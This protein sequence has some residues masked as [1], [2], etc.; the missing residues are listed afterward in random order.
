MRWPGYG[1]SDVTLTPRPWIRHLLEFHD[2]REI[3][4]ING[5][6][7][8]I[9]NHKTLRIP[10]LHLRLTLCGVG[11]HY[12]NPWIS[13]MTK[14]SSKFKYSFT[15]FATSLTLQCPGFSLKWA[16]WVLTISWSSKW[17]RKTTRLNPVDTLGF[18]FPAIVSWFP[19]FL[20]FLPWVEE[21][22]GLA[23]LIPSCCG[24]GRFHQ[25]SQ[26]DAPA[27][28]VNWS[29][30]L[31]LMTCIVSLSCQNVASIPSPMSLENLAI[32]VKSSSRYSVWG[33]T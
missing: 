21:V 3:M 28:P 11:I 16:M 18:D 5:G 14:S 30:T 27:G 23:V 10:W 19:A 6:I 17:A 13:T 1:G 25:S 32:L 4:E 7:L 20:C 8:T 9:H 15:S 12:S 26:L 24:E 29:G 33:T 31:S 2:F 22:P